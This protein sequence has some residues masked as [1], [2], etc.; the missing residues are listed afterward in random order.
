MRDVG[1]DEDGDVGA[2]ALDDEP[3]ITASAAPRC[4][5]ASFGDE[6]GGAALREVLARDRA[7]L[8]AR[9]N[10]VVELGPRGRGAPDLL[11]AVGERA[12]A[13]RAW[14]RRDSSPR[15][16]GT[17]RL[18][19]LL[20]RAPRPGCRRAWRWPRRRTRAMNRDAREGRD[21]AKRSRNA[22]QVHSRP[23]MSSPAGS[24]TA[25]SGFASS[26]SRRAASAAW[27]LRVMGNRR[28]PA[29]SAG[30]TSLIRRLGLRRLDG[31]WLSRQLDAAGCARTGAGAADGC[32]A[33]LAACGGTTARGRRLHRGRRRAFEPPRDRSRTRARRA[34]RQPATMPPI[35]AGCRL[36]RVICSSAALRPSVVI[37]GVKL[38]GVICAGRGDS[39]R[40]GRDS[41]DTALGTPWPFAIA[42]SSRVTCPIDT[43]RSAGSFASR[44]RIKASRSPGR[45][46]VIDRGCGRLRVRVLRA[47]LGD[48][49]R[50]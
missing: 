18:L 36:A 26:V 29:A 30:R 19:A 44:R 2:V 15:T 7:S 23:P 40:I 10:G 34:P 28:R 33:R 20:A 25:A 49:R 48:R 3:G 43:Q 6:R 37:D 14:G 47:R 5:F 50:R 11:V 16:A 13:R 22:S 38:G 8:C 1:A 21:D 45:S 4:S 12:A 39:A 41:R 46:G 24:A 35:S 31:R 27:R 9:L 32:V 17:P 42:S